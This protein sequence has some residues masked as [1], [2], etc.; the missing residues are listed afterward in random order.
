MDGD[1]SK[2]GK[3]RVNRIAGQ[4]AGIQRMVDEGRYCVEILNQIAAVRSALDQLG[5]QMLTGHLE[6]CVL[7]AEQGRQ[8]DLL[9]EDADEEED[10][11]LRVRGAEPDQHQ[12]RERD[13]RHVADEIGERLQQRLHR[14]PAADE[15]AQRQRQQRR[16]RPAGDHAQGAD[17]GVARRCHRDV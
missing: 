11:L 14:A 1:G 9:E 7:H 10:Q 2:K 16:Q 13:C 6:S 5:V 3:T 4:V 15:E 12:R 8:E 17:G